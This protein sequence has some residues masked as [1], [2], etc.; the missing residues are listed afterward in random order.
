VDRALAFTASSALS[1]TRF[2]QEWLSPLAAGLTQML[3]LLKVVGALALL[4]TASGA[5]YV[6]GT[7]PAH[8]T[9]TETVVSEV[10][11]RETVWINKTESRPESEPVAPAPSEASA[12]DH[13]P[14]LHYEEAPACGGEQNVH[15]FLSSG[16]GATGPGAQVSYALFV[17]GLGNATY[18]HGVTGAV[19]FV[20][21]VCDGQL[22]TRPAALGKTATPLTLPPCQNGYRAEVRPIV[23]SDVPQLGTAVGYRSDPL[24]CGYDFFMPEETHVSLCMEWDGELLEPWTPH[25]GADGAGYLFDACDAELDVMV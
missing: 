9:V 16:I 10:I 23:V 18:T 2:V 7:G 12:A 11:L 24:G 22:V 19:L 15:W 20:L 14:R 1:P 25:V 6:V 21:V 8:Q 4:V 17:E 13:D 5:S 3:S